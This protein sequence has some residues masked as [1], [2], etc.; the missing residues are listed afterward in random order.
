MRQIKCMCR[1]VSEEMDAPAVLIG[2]TPA[3][4]FAA[5]KADAVFFSAEYGRDRAVAAK[6][7]AG[8]CTVTVLYWAAISLYSGA[9]LIYLGADGAFCPVQADTS[10]VR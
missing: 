8:L 3:V 4:F 7:K 1:A 6:I 10:E 9:V 2:R 5:W